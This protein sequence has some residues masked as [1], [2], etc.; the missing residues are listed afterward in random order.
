LH[1]RARRKCGR[2]LASCRRALGRRPIPLSIP[3]GVLKAFLIQSIEI[4]FS[5]SAT[6]SEISNRRERT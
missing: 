5:Q 3:A 1:P 6:G 2:A 4:R